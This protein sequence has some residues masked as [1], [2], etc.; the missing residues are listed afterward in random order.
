MSGN[1]LNFKFFPKTILKFSAEDVKL[2]FEKPMDTFLAKFQNFVCS[3]SKEKYDNKIPL[4][5][6]FISIVFRWTRRMQF[7]QFGNF[8]ETNF[9]WNQKIGSYF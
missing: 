7:W 5:Q 2:T 9:V 6:V 4:N 1:I 8:F 3:S